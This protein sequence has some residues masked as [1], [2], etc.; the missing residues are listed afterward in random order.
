LGW[1]S[2]S[3]VRSR[4]QEER[5]SRK[6]RPVQGAREYTVPTWTGSTEDQKKAKSRLELHVAPQK[7]HQVVSEVE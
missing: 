6:T 2:P 4:I 3:I 5:P 1:M 7:A